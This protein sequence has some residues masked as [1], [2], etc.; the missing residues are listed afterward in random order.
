[1][2]FIEYEKAENATEALDKLNGTKLKESVLSIHKARSGPPSAEEYATK[3]RK[4]F[5]HCSAFAR[6]LLHFFYSYRIVI[7]AYSS[8]GF[9][10]Q[11]GSPSLAASSRFASLSFALSFA[12]A[13]SSPQPP[14]SFP[15][16]LALPLPLSPVPLPSSIT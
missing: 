14:L 4:D 15:F 6:F 7:A 1:M 16:P 10:L 11:V 12:L 9:L 13:P 5:F 2:A 3:G 8:V